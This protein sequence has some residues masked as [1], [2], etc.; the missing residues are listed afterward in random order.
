MQKPNPVSD[1]VANSGGSASQSSG[2][3]AENVAESGGSASPQKSGL[4]DNA[5]AKSDDQGI[6][7]WGGSPID[8]N[9]GYGNTTKSAPDLFK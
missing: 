8:A 2:T 6:S 1:N 9:K 5:P 4:S 7:G 3:V